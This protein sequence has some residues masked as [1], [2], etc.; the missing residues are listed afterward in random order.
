M[1]KKG[2]AYWADGLLTAL[3]AFLAYIVLAYFHEWLNLTRTSLPGIDYVYLPAG[4]KIVAILTV[5]YWGALGVGL[6][7]LLMSWY[8]WPG[9]PF[10]TLTVKSVV[11][12]L[13]TL[14]AILALQRLLRL[15][16]DLSGLT[17][18]Q[19]TGLTLLTAL[20]TGVVDGAANVLLG[21]RSP[22]DYW[23]GVFAMALGDFTGAI[24]LFS[25][26]TAVMHW[27]SR[28]QLGR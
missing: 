12:V 1:M 21:L 28:R 10:Y 14:L 7:N 13:V 26:L 16:P 22:H 17:F 23:S 20:I 6:G 9:T 18:A 5:R 8:L 2:D 27:L 15:R 24:I 3:L 11:W 4:A 25:V 19:L